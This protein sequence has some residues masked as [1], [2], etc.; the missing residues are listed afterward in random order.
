[1]DRIQQRKRLSVHRR[2][3]RSSSAADEFTFARQL[4][5]RRNRGKLHRQK[6]ALSAV[7]ASIVLLGFNASVAYHLAP[8]LTFFAQELCRLLRR[9]DHRLAAYAHEMLLR[10]RS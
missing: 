8:A 1:R 4:F 10:V 6:D 5:P 2:F 3:R 9:A 7:Q